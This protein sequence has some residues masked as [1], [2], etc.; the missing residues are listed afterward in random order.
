[1]RMIG[2]R[3]DRKNFMEHITCRL[4][5]L[6]QQEHG[7]GIFREEIKIASWTVRVDDVTHSFLPLPALNLTCGCPHI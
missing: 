5:R 7:L 6:R 3:H 2:F 1:M 4:W